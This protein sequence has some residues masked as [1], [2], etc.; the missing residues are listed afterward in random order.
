MILS[1]PSTLVNYSFIGKK[2]L[3]NALASI[4]PNQPKPVQISQDQSA[5]VTFA[6]G[7]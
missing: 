5:R 7:F 6:F 4:S 2:M 3:F 1:F